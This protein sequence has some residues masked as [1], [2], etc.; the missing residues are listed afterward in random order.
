MKAYRPQW[1]LEDT[2]RLVC[3]AKEGWPVSVIS[4]KVKRSEADVWVKLL[5]LRLAPPVEL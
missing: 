2:H 1:S 5:E 4:L 3:L